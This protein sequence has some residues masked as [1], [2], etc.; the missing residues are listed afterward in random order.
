MASQLRFI[1]AGGTAAPGWAWARIQ[2]STWAHLVGMRGWAPATFTE[3][4]V[5]SLLA[6][7]VQPR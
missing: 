1:Q 2:P 5:S 3:R 4:I 7:L 6:E